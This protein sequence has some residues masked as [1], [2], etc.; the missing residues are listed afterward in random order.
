MRLKRLYV[1]VLEYLYLRA[2]QSRHVS[3]TDPD[4]GGHMVLR[5][6][7]NDPRGRNRPFIM[8]QLKNTKTN[9]IAGILMSPRQAHGLEMYLHEAI[10]DQ[11][12]K[13]GYMPLDP[14]EYDTRY[15]RVP[16]KW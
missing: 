5:W 9:A 10:G 16:D 1:R 12:A 14:P 8:A 2:I 7:W 6:G 3:G 15:I 13:F 4:D 11:A